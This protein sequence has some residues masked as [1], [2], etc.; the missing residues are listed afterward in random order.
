MTIL[1]TMEGVRHDLTRY[2][3]PFLKIGPVD[4]MYDSEN[5]TGRPGRN[6]TQK[7][8]G[9]RKI[10]LKLLLKADSE[11]HT[12]ML[13]DE[14]ASILDVAKD[15]YIYEQVS[16]K[17][18]FEFPGQTHFQS[19][20]DRIKWTPLLYKRWRVERINNDAIEWNG[21]R[22]TRVIEFETS[23]LPFAVSPY[24]SLQLQ[25]YGKQWDSNMYSWEMGLEWD[26]GGPNFTFNQS[27]FTVKNHGNVDVNPRHM[28][29]K[30]ALRGHFP[31]G[32]TVT[33]H[34]T[35]ESVTYNGSLTSSDTFVLDGVY[36]LKNGAHVT[37]ATNKKLI[38]LQPKDNQFSISGGTVHSITFD[39]P[40]YFI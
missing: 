37:S 22:G 28:P 10:Q 14:L 7:Y 21:L 33:N 19:Y 6:R 39:Y 38:T 20:Q 5:V 11:M 4:I 2:G 18:G 32:F 8:Y 13:R 27:Y 40:F 30:I 35:G 23:E 36:Y 26:N 34:T 17:P 3:I 31:N 15:F 29:L 9:I 16:E 24:T 25:Q 1:E 12:I